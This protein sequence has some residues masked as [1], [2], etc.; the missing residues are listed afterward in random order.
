MNVRRGDVVLSDHNR[1]EVTL[2]SRN[3]QGRF[4]TLVNLAHGLRRQAANRASDMLLL[5]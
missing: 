5:Y 2:A 4:E 3:P 1:F